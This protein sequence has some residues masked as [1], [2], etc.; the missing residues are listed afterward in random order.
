MSG[1]FGS[2]NFEDMGGTVTGKVYKGKGV[3]KI[4]NLCMDNLPRLFVSN[5]ICIAAAIPGMTG[6]AVGYRFGNPLFLLV[7]GVV[8]GLLL[9]PFYG[10]MVDGILT[11]LRGF[12]GNWWPRYCMV[13]KRD[14]KSYLLPG[15]LTG[16]MVAMVAEVLM[17]LSGGGE[18][19]MLLLWTTMIALVLFLMYSIYVWPQ[20]VLLDLTFPQILKNCLPMFLAHFP[21]TAGALAIQLAYWGMMLILFPYSAIFLLVLGL[22]FPALMSTNAVYKNIN[23]DFHIE[24]RLGI[25]PPGEDGPAADGDG[26][27]D[28]Y[29][30]EEDAGDD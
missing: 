22:W 7:S 5:L 10:T 26:S 9:G 16:I 24:E 30:E 12:P 21:T 13:L 25:V 29:G 8:L 14:W 27:E 11:A 19:P 17:V 15:L 2:Q 1:L 28:E 23:Q 6:L 18:L 20:R 4:W 3:G